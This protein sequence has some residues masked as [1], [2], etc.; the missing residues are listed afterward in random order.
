MPGRAP[1]GAGDASAAPA[2][3]IRWLACRTGI[4]AAYG[5][6]S[7]KLRRATFMALIASALLGA[8][9]LVR[10]QAREQPR[11]QP[12]AASDPAWIQLQNA[13][14]PRE[15]MPPHTHAGA[16]LASMQLEHAAGGDDPLA[17]VYIITSRQTYDGIRSIARNG[18]ARRDSTGATRVV[19]EI[20][21][22]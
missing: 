8:P 3:P 5:S 4:L 20:K 17:P 13:F 22:H 10:E 21:S 15:R 2:I 1:G 19:S 16:Q 14:A 11:V 6:V 12:G 18:V 9:A 7:M